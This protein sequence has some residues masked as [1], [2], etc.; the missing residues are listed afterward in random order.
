[1]NVH[2]TWERSKVQ[3]TIVTYGAKNEP[4]LMRILLIFMKIF[5]DAQFRISSN[6]VM[7]Q[8]LCT[9]G[10]SIFMVFLTFVHDCVHCCFFFCFVCSSY[11]L[12]HPL[13]FLIFTLRVMRSPRHTIYARNL[14]IHL[15]IS[16]RPDKYHYAVFSSSSL[17]HFTYEWWCLYWLP[18]KCPCT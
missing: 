2:G 18:W 5:I 9:V 17:L 4:P 8:T 13:L 10:M 1:M 14:F 11:H 12:L 15:V 16:V 6:L 7:F 3:Q